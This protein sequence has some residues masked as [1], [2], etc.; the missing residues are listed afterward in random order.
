MDEPEDEDESEDGA[1][2]LKDIYD[3]LP[4]Y[5]HSAVDEAKKSDWGAVDRS[6]TGTAIIVTFIGFSFLTIGIVQEEVNVDW[7][8]IVSILGISGLVRFAPIAIIFWLAS[9]LADFMAGDS[10][11]YSNNRQILLII[12]GFARVAVGA[13][14]IYLFYQAFLSDAFDIWLLIGV[15]LAFAGILTLGTVFVLGGVREIYNGT[16]DH[17]D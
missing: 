15:F 5:L 2:F 11:S 7:K 3:S 14:L 9:K 17:L 6:I 10:E 8:L 13:A 4:G 16:I 12:S 1:T